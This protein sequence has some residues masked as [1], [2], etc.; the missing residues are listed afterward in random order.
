M[1]NISR[2]FKVGLVAVFILFFFTWGYNFLKGFQFFGATPRVYY[3]LYEDIE[4]L[5][6]ESPV[7]INGYKVGKVTDIKLQTKNEK[8]RGKLLVEFSIRTN[9]KFS[10][11]SQVFIATTNLLGRKSLIIKPVYDDKNVAVSGDYLQGLIKE[12]I[13]A[14]I[15]SQLVPVKSKIQN[16]L[17]HMDSVMVATSKVLSQKN[18]DHLEK[19]LNNLQKSTQRIDQMLSQNTPY[20][21]KTIYNVHRLSDTLANANIGL[22]MKRITFTVGQLQTLTQG[23]QKGKGTLGKLFTDDELYKNLNKALLQMDS[24]LKELKQHPK[25]FVHFSIFGRKDKAPQK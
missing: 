1:K 18:I 5:D 19:S 3:V 6:I 20:F 16:L 13:M 2:E 23:L 11:S 9:L 10:K 17:T 12:D 21:N 4:G 14:Q 7:L 24:L 8:N 25:R 15:K 22:L